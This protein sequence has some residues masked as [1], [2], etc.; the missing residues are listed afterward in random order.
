MDSFVAEQQEFKQQSEGFKWWISK[1][2]FSGMAQEFYNNS[3]ENG[4]DE[5]QQQEKQ[6]IRDKYFCP[7]HSDGYVET[8]SSKVTINRNLHRDSRIFM[9]TQNTAYGPFGLYADIKKKFKSGFSRLTFKHNNRE[10]KQMSLRVLM[11]CYDI[12]VEDI[13]RWGDNQ[14]EI[15]WLLADEIAGVADADTSF[16][17]NIKVQDKTK[18]PDIDVEM[19]GKSK[20]EVFRNEVSRFVSYCLET[21]FVRCDD[22]D[23]LGT[24]VVRQRLFYLEP[25][26]TKKRDIMMRFQNALRTM[27][28]AYYNNLSS[29]N[30]IDV[31][32]SSRKLIVSYDQHVGFTSASVSQIIPQVKQADEFATVFFRQEPKCVRGIYV[33]NYAGRIVRWAI[34]GPEF[35]DG[36]RWDQTSIK[37]YD[38]QGLIRQGVEITN[39]QV[40]A[41]KIRVDGNIIAKEELRA[42][43]DNPAQVIRVVR[44]DK[45]ILIITRYEYSLKM[46]DKMVS[47]AAQK[48][49]IS[50]IVDQEDE[51]AD[52]IINPCCIPSRMTLGQI[53]EGVINNYITSRG[54]EDL[55]YPVLC[56]PFAK[57]T[58]KFCQMVQQREGLAKTPGLDDLIEN[59]TGYWY[60]WNRYYVLGHRVDE[61]Y[62]VRGEGNPNNT[63]MHT[64]QPQKGRK[65]GGGLRVGVMERDVLLSHN[66]TNTLKVL[67]CENGDQIRCYYC[68]DMLL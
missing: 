63:N 52:L 23:H 60:C 64:E 8:P 17:N 42:M 67:F 48:G 22:R 34:S 16:R 2:G 36:K 45:Q 18:L 33:N 27:S 12:S 46:G 6:E 38:E 11:S 29:R 47:S 44:T 25:Q 21:M 9:M 65:L 1:Y 54:L 49:V 50:T 5:H 59:K 43:V 7:M 55:L 51:K 20:D 56:P 61:K 39:G 15:G 53:W 14:A 26:M 13:T 41:T 40:L 4:F 58:E 57:T 32:S 68:T 28:D 10:F 66:S 19:F 62:R 37:D 24:K 30:Q 3:F 35:K 31:W